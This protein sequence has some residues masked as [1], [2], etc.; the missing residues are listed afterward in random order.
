ME[1]PMAWV[2]TLSGPPTIPRTPNVEVF[3]VRSARSYSRHR[4]EMGRDYVSYQEYLPKSS[5][6]SANYELIVKLEYTK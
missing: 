6:E 3:S 5:E 1:M 2:A 4:H